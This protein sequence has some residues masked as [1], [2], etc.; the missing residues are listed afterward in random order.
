MHLAAIA[1]ASL[2]RMLWGCRNYRVQ[3]EYSGFDWSLTGRTF[4]DSNDGHTG[5]F[6]KVPHFLFAHHWSLPAYCKRREHLSSL[7]S[8]LAPHSPTPSF[9][10]TR[11]IYIAHSKISLYIAYVFS[12]FERKDFP[13]FPTFCM[14]PCCIFV[15]FCCTVP[16]RNRSMMQ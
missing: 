10:V 15:Y 7:H 12:L 4:T 3:S 13:G 16:Y 8:T 9:W 11:S 5:Y 6:A 14:K 2:Q 1:W